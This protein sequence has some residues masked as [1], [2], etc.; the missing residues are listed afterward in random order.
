[1]DN[2]YVTNKNLYNM[3]YLLETSL[4]EIIKQIK[5]EYPYDNTMCKDKYN[6]TIQDYLYE[7]II[8]KL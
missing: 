3:N 4:T 7:E 6:E 5:L 2:I 1:L 8:S